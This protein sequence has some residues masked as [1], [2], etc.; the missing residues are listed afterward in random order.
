MVSRPGCIIWLDSMQFGSVADNAFIIVLQ[1][2]AIVSC[3]NAIDPVLAA[4]VVEKSR[5]AKQVLKHIRNPLLAESASNNV[6]TSV[7]LGF[8]ILLTR[9]AGTAGQIV[10][11]LFLYTIAY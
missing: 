8:S 4:T 1:S 2:I 7:C 5:F 11:S 3:F 10:Q 9:F 6:T